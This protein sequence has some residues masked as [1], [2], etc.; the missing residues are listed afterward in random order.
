MADIV[1]NVAKGRVVEL[2]N[3]VANNDPAN[4]GLVLVLFK[5]SGLVADATMVDYDTLA[6]VTAGASVEAD[7]ASYSRAVL[8]DADVSVGTVDDSNDEYYVDLADEVWSSLDGDEIGAMLVCYDP[9]TTA[10]TDANI[11]PL[12]KHDFSINPNGGDVTAQF[13]AN[14]YAAGT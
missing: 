13:A 3:R 1:F 6:A 14:G 2:H 7:D 5:A 12:T 4:S 11:V 10:G 8:T 9:D